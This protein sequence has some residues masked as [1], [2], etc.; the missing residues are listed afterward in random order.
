[1]S[2]SEPKLSDGDVPGIVAGI[3]SVF[4]GAIKEALAGESDDA[5]PP[6]IAHRFIAIYKSLC[7]A[8]FSP[9]DQKTAETALRLLDK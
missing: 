7:D 8:G 9:N 4:P 5:R 6:A 2:Q 3:E 1:M